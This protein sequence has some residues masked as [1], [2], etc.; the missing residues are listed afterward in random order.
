[1]N[2]ER[3]T[4]AI[5]DQRLNLKNKYIEIIVARIPTELGSRSKKGL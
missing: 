4:I 1:M 5:G 3:N 2:S